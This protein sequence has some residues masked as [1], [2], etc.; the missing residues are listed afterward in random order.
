MK[1]ILTTVVASVALI[2][3]AAAR[4]LYVDNVRGLETNDGLAAESGPNDRGPFKTIHRGLRTAEP[5]DTAYLIK[6]EM[7]DSVESE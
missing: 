7:T 5:G 3:S 1:P 2:N 4:Y 6:N